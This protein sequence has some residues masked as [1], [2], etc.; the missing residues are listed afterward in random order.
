MATLVNYTCKSFIKLTLGVVHLYDTYMGGVDLS[1]QRVVSYA[2]LMAEWC[3]TTRCS[4]TCWKCAYQMH[5]FCI[6]NPLIMSGLPVQSSG[7]Q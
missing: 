2:R 1:D 4:S 3:G 5:I 7:S 6:L